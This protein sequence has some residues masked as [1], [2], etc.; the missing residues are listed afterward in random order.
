MLMIKLANC[1]YNIAILYRVIYMDFSTNLKGFYQMLVLYCLCTD[2]YWMALQQGPVGG[3]LTTKKCIFKEYL[4]CV[5]NFISEVLCN[6]IS[7]NLMIKVSKN[8]F[9]FK[10][11]QYKDRKWE[12]NFIRNWIWGQKKQ[13]QYDHIQHS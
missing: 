12:R 3:G 6:Y 1:F 11:L 4:I 13:P 10:G 8:I 9:F 5:C 7:L 2:K